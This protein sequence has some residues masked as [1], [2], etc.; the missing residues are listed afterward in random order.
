MYSSLLSSGPQATLTKIYNA[1]EFLQIS[2]NSSYPMDSPLTIHEKL[3][4][5]A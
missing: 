1:L 5:A 4:V 2:K 3:D